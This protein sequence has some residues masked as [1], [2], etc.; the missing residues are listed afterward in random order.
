[1]RLLRTSSLHTFYL[2]LFTFYLIIVAV[3][4]PRPGG[5]DHVLHIVSALPVEQAVC[6]LTVAVYGGNI[7]LAA[8]AEFVVQLLA[9]NFLEGVEHLQDGNTVAA[10]EVE[11]FAVARTFAAQQELQGFHMRVGDVGDVDVVADA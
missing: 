9:R 1:M 7:T 3:V 6:F 8:F 5:F 10:A 4:L 11:N 2:V